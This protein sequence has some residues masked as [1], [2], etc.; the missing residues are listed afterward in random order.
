[1]SSTTTA[2]SLAIKPWTR[3]NTNETALKDVLAR[4]N[5]ERGHFRDITEASLQEE[6]ATEGA[7]ETSSSDEEEDEEEAE[8]GKDGR[9]K[10]P[11]T[12]EEL[13]AAKMKMMEVASVAMNDTLLSLDFVALLESKYLPRQAAVSISPWTKQGVPLST[14]GVDLWDQKA[15]PVDQAREA[16]DALLASKVRMK[17]LQQSADDLL[18]AATRLQDNVRKET[19]FWDQILSI[20]DKWNVSRIPRTHLLGVHFGFSGCARAFAGRNLAALVGDS[21]GAVSLERGIGTRPKAVRAL[22]KKGAQVV[23]SSRLP[24]LSDDDETTLEARIRHARDSVYDEELYHE[25]IRETRSL[26]SLGLSMKGSAIT[27]ATGVDEAYTM[28]LE[29]ISLDE[30]NSLPLD[31]LHSADALAQATLVT[32]RLLLG[33]KHREK[34]HKKQEIPPPISDKQDNKQDDVSIMRPLVQ[35]LKH[36]STLSRLNTYL[37]S[38][39]KLVR[40]LHMTG[41]SAECQ[42]A[43]M[44]LPVPSKDAVTAELLICSV[45]KGLIS[46]GALWVIAKDDLTLEMKVDVETKH[47]EALE[48]QSTV[49]APDGTRI[50]FDSLNDALSGADDFLAIVL[51]TALAESLGGNWEFDKREGTLSRPHGGGKKREW[52]WFEVDGRQEKAVVLHYKGPEEKKEARWSLESTGRSM[53]DSLKELRVDLSS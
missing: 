22:V 9:P 50:T 53:A 3:D 19:V 52:L 20:S 39:A 6:I 15:M 10:P 47:D 34:M 4:V 40:S 41:A 17:T 33:Q 36:H 43:R 16:Q 32:A 11:T 48:P 25:M 26:T 28:D 8:S 29:L 37:N 13:F 7:L 27:F 14:M 21:E 30:D 38:M 31:A 5:L 23:G 49:Q 12:R 18:A 35:L 2:T 44:S 42:P 24:T 51:G 45:L 1:M 46:E